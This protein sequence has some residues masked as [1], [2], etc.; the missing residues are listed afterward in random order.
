MLM[1]SPKTEKCYKCDAVATGREHVPPQCIF[2]EQKDAN[3]IDYR[4]QLITVPSCDEH[5]QKKTNEDEFFM[6]SITPCVGNNLI[7][8]YQTKT[9]VKRAYEN[10]QPEFIERILNGVKVVN[11][12]IEN[13]EPHDLWLGEMDQARMDKCVKLISSGLYYEEYKKT[14]KGNFSIIYGF[15]IDQNHITRDYKFFINEKLKTEFGEQKLKGANPEIFNY[16]FIPE[17]AF[18]LTV[19]KMFF[20]EGAMILVLFISEGADLNAIQQV[21]QNIE[22]EALDNLLAIVKISDNVTRLEK[23][24]EY[25]AK[26]PPSTHYY[27]L[28]GSTYRD[29]KQF[30]EAKKEYLKSLTL[31]SNNVEA[32]HSLAYL[33]DHKF[34]NKEEA[35]T[36]Y[37]KALA[38]EPTLTVG[39]LNLGMLLDSKFDDKEAAKDQYEI[40]LSYDSNEVRAHNNLA[41]YY[42]SFS[43]RDSQLKTIFHFKKAIK[44][45][46]TYIDAYLNYGSF[47]QEMN[48][49]AKSREILE[50]A[51][52]LSTSEQESKIIDRLLEQTK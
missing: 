51:K 47:L 1:K 29:L 16:Q 30:E 46:P 35:R 10:K 27:S 11:V 41:N 39:R 45:N 20:F 13:G 50:I 9:K 14:F 44:I 8:L 18:G 3:N 12:A 15:T 49:K 6:M 32:L 38:I 17:D 25:L 23:L 2:P 40:I 33:Y 26:F 7:G 21:N 34:D 48:Q 4:K 22:W 37:E 42:R 43:D 24:N 52:L 36:Y 28:K 31:D 5:N 19:L